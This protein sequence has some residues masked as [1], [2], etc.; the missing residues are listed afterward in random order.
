MEGLNP[1]KVVSLVF[2]IG[3]AVVFTL[4]FGPGSFSK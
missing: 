1:R 4:N 2:I 3:I